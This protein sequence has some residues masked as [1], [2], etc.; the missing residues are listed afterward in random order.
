MANVLLVTTEPEVDPRRGAGRRDFD[1]LTRSA[2]RDRFGIHRLVEN[3]QQADLILFVG[4]FEPGFQ[5]VRRHA[6]VR[7]MRERCF[8]V[9]AGDNVIPFLPGVY[10]SIERR[11]YS[12]SR[13][14][15]GSYLRVFS[16]PT[17]EHFSNYH[18]CD[19]LYSF[20]GTFQ[21]SPVRAR[22]SRLQ[23]PHGEVRDSCD[24]HGPV[25]QTEYAGLLRRSKFILCP[26]GL[27]PSSWRIFESMK[28]GRVP[29]IISDQW[30]PPSG[31]AWDE[32]SL[33]VAEGSIDRIPM[34]LESLQGDAEHMGRIAR[35]VWE[36]WF[37]E[38]TAFH[39][40]VEWCLDMQRQRRMPE[41]IARW[42]VYIQL[43]RP[44]HFRHI[45]LRGLKSRIR[46]LKTSY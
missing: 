45:V 20:L 18:E 23:H 11:W 28:A 46:S 16:N 15:T 30:V 21:T 10:T 2:H 34:L 6:F 19:L 29:V 9:D 7:R 12:N 39:R 22:L 5:D 38:E 17:I 31:P 8:L 36:Q 3:S 32:F 24:R 44:R 25:E 37:S 35:A 42:P 26:R 27:G 41:S 14:R 43:L 1:F 40:I 13:T 33:R 4:S